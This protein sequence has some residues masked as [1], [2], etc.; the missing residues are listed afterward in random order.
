MDKKE[1]IADQKNAQNSTK[2]EMIQCTNNDLH[3]PKKSISAPNNILTFPF[4]P[5]T[6]IL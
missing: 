3:A 1:N 4:L 6:K 2:L 5:N